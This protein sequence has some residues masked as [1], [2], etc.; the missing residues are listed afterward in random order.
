[1]IASESIRFVVNGDELT[2]LKYA[3]QSRK[4]RAVAKVK[5]TVP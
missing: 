3:L 1:M 5:S 4:W 2:K